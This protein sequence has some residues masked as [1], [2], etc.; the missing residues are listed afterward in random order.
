MNRCLLPQCRESKVSC[1]RYR[2]TDA[3]RYDEVDMKPQR[4]A[5][6]HL[7]VAFFVLRENN[8]SIKNCC[9]KID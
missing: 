5:E 8:Y 9:I 6:S 3:I 2:L 4:I 7:R 1:F